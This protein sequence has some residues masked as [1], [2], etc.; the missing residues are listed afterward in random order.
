MPIENI[1]VTSIWQN[2]LAKL[3]ARRKKVVVA[4]VNRALPYRVA[5]NQ[6]FIH[7]D[8]P[9]LQARTEKDDYRLLIEEVLT[10]I[11]GQNFRLSVLVEI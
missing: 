3:N 4:C 7:F 6:F 5:E 11:T 10:E 2:V 1:D 8:S 9:F